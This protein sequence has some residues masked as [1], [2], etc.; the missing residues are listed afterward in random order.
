MESN[1]KI[2]NFI[3]RLFLIGFLLAWCLILI[4]PFIVITLWG[5]VIAIALFLLIVCRRFLFV[6]ED[7]T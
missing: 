3:I 2:I 1:P 6:L 4:R 7:F 5:I